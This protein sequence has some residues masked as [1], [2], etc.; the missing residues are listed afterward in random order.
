MYPRNVLTLIARRPSHCYA[1]AMA[2]L[3]RLHLDTATR[4]LAPTLTHVAG[5]HRPCRPPTKM[6][7]LSFFFPPFIKLLQDNNYH[8]IATPTSL[9]QTQATPS[10]S[11]PHRLHATTVAPSTTGAR[12]RHDCRHLDPAA[13][14]PC[15]PCTPTSHTC[16][17]ATLQHLGP[18]PLVLI[19][20][21]CTLYSYKYICECNHHESDLT[22]SWPR[23]D[24]DITMG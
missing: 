21:A 18:I 17:A 11:Q 7:F 13:Y 16:T 8:I 19:V 2:L 3:H 9:A 23:I 12:P 15:R 4:R 10:P 14:Q 1:T 5:T 6:S 24:Y 20:V 22:V